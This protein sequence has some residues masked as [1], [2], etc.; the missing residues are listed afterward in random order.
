M[1]V[2]FGRRMLFGSCLGDLDG[3]GEGGATTMWWLVVAGSLLLRTHRGG[4]G[5]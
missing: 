2:F 4:F 1:I 5:W 3:G